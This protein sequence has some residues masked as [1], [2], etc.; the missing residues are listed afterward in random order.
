[1]VSALYKDAKPNVSA[2]ILYKLCDALGVKCDHFKPFLR[3]ET[4]E[5]APESDEAQAL[6]PP[7]KRGRKRKK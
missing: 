4:Q 1:M 3:D 7:E 6:A 5:P 2:V